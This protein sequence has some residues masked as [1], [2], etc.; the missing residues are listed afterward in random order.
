MKENNIV[1]AANTSAG[2]PRARAH[3]LN[4]AIQLEEI[5]PVNIINIAI[6]FTGGLLVA[7]VLWAH[8]TQI[9]E[10]ATTRG[11]VIPAD[12]IHNVQHLE[13]GIVSEILVRNGDF[14]KQGT[15]PATFCT[16]SY[17]V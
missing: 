10:V 7:L 9:K 6:M 16:T 17:H 12:L 14:V 2:L 5:T 8:F 13:G 15:I 1:F 4:Q 3:Y 11:E